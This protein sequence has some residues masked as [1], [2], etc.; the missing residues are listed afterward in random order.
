M[1]DIGTGT[2]IWAIEFALEHPNADV[3]GTDLSPIQPAFVPPNCRFEVD[4]FDDDWAYG[5][6]FDYVHGRYLCLF[7]RDLQRLMQQCFDNLRP[8]G[9]CEFMETVL[10]IRSVDGTIEGTAIQRW[11]GLVLQGIRRTG[12][13]PL[14]AY[15]Y[16]DYMQRVGFVNVAV[17]KFYMPVHTWAKGRDQK[18]MGALQLTNAL[19]ALSPLSLGI[20]VKVLGWKQEDLEEFLVDVR[21]EMT[22]KSI[23]AYTP[24]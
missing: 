21:R 19:E 18:I 1:L 22:D 7:I 10:D 9:W 20:F 6:P 4:D 11:N 23:H 13:E 17:K 3:L 14:C 16:A 2:G 15:S 5:T 12:R 24:M 8:G